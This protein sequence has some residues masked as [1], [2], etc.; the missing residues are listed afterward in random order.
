MAQLHQC[1]ADVECQHTGAGQ[2]L[3]KPI[4]GRPIIRGGWL[5]IGHPQA[6]KHD[7]THDDHQRQRIDVQAQPF[8]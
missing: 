6:T 8:E 4:A 3:E 2:L 1:N 7:A 5:R